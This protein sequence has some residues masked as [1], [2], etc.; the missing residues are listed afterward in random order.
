MFLYIVVKDARHV[1]AWQDFPTTTTTSRRTF[2]IMPEF[3]RIKYLKEKTFANYSSMDEC[4]EMLG[5]SKRQLYR[6]LQGFQV[7]RPS[8]IRAIQL[9]DYIKAK[10]LELPS[11]LDVF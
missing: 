7:P 4:A 3:D 5:I 8:L 1:I 9:E 11:P 6:Y 2:F 10:G